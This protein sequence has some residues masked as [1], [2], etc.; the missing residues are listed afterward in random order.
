MVN[1]TDR[2]QRCDDDDDDD[3]LN[4][5][6]ISDIGPFASSLG[7]PG[8]CLSMVFSLSVVEL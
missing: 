2:M 4:H 8:K 3:S 1:A 5:G 7:S 6:L